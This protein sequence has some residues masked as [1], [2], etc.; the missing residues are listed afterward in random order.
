MLGFRG[1]N[2]ASKAAKPQD[3]LAS[4]LSMASS[5]LTSGGGKARSRRYK[6]EIEKILATGHGEVLFIA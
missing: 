6:A 3:T 5:R 4:G 2:A 1:R